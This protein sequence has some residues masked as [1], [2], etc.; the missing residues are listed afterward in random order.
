M[1]L[2]MF[3]VDTCQWRNVTNKIVADGENIFI[4]VCNLVIYENKKP[5]NMNT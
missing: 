2:G 5:S 1:F 3:W 4:S